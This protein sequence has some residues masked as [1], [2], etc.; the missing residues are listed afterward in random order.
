MPLKSKPNSSKFSKKSGAPLLGCFMAHELC[1][2]LLLSLEQ[3]P[4][5]LRTADSAS[6]HLGPR[7]FAHAILPIRKSPPI[8]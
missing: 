2:H 5:S 8:P 6:A 7:T 3:A 4:L 1:T